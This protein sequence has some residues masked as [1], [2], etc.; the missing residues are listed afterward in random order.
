MESKIPARWTLKDGRVIAISSISQWGT[1]KGLMDGVP[2]PYVNGIILHGLLDRE[3]KSSFDTPSHDTPSG[4]PDDFTNEKGKPYLVPPKAVPAFEGEGALLPRY[5]CSAIFE[6]GVTKN[7]DPNCDYSTL[8]VIWL[9]DEFAFPVD[10]LVVTA[11][12]DIDW[13]TFAKDTYDF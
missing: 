8:E 2:G 5:I 6:S 4:L 7:S 13:D 1:Y 12:Q 11:F 3:G 9:Q 10:P